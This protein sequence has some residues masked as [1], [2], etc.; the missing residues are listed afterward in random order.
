VGDKV[1]YNSP[2]RPNDSQSLLTYYEDLSLSPQVYTI[3]AGENIRTI[4]KNLLGNANS[5]KEIWATNPSIQSKG[6]VE[7]SYE[8]RYWNEGGP[9]VATSLAQNNFNNNNNNNNN[10][11]VEEEFTPPPPP[12]VESLPPP[13][14]PVVAQNNVPPPPPVENIQEE[15]PP[16]PPPIEEFARKKLPLRLIKIRL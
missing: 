7:D 10:F 4:S 5:W 14:P 15:L 1:Y 8:L 9:A 3:Q 11:P 2:Q 16:P 12:P 6:N 13:P